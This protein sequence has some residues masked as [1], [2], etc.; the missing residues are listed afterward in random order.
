MSGLSLIVLEPEKSGSNIFSKPTS[1]VLK[2]PFEVR[3]FWGA[4]L[5]FLAMYSLFLGCI[6]TRSAS[7]P[8]SHRIRHTL[9]LWAF[10]SPDLEIVQH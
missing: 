3:H 5:S 6:K 4:Y 7:A 10:P 9:L 8:L 2:L 1:V